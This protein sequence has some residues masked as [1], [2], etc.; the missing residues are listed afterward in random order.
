MPDFRTI[1]ILEV[2][3]IAKENKNYLRNVCKDSEL[4]TFILNHYSLQGVKRS[5]L[6]NNYLFFY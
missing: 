1:N 2:I 3:K 6:T 5:I 4:R